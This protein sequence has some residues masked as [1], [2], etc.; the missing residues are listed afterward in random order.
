MYLP[1]R[2]DPVIGDDALGRHRRPACGCG[3]GFA[4]FPLSPFAGFRRRGAVNHGEQVEDSAPGLTPTQTLRQ[5]SAVPEFYIV[6]TCDRIEFWVPCKL[7]EKWCRGTELNRRRQP[8][9]GCALP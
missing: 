5:T 1:V 9:Q 8:F 6:T 2:D 3:L 7:L 4:P